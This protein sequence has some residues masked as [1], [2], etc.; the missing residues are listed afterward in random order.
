MLGCG[1][2]VLVTNNL[3]S[4][5]HLGYRERKKKFEG[6][7]SPGVELLRAMLASSTLTLPV[8]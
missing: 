8:L 3:T 5:P 1:S 6:K 7:V 4:C 2:H